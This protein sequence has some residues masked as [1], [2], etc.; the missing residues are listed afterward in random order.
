M[1]AYA[2]KGLTLAQR[3]FHPMEGECYALIWGIMHFKQYLH[4]N[5]FTLRIDHKPLEWLATV[6]DAHG[7]RGRWIDM[8]QDFS[9][10]ILHR[11]GLK[12]TNIDALSRNPVGQATN[13]DDFSEEIQD[14]ET[15]QDDSIETTGRIFSVQYGKESDWFGFRRH[16]RE[17]TEHHRCYFGINHWHWS[18]D[19]QLFMLNVVTEINQEEDTNSL[20]EDVEATDN[21]ESQN[22]GPAD[23]R[24]SLKREMTRYYDRQQQL[25]L[26][27]VAQK[28]SEFGEHELGHMES[29]EEETC[30][31]DTRSIDIWK[32]ATCLGLLKGG[33]LPNTVDPEESKR[34]RKRITNY[35]WKEERFYF[36]VYMCPNQRKE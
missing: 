26:V 9:F 1:V 2:N 4:R 33:I 35:C 7:R 36:K 27:L 21:E 24:Q 12:H 19:H 18:E 25:E 14:I 3:K 8:L 10:K 23:G 22:L 16:S 30:E 31:M 34:V 29:G 11:P 5:H 13:D 6:S 17:L 28:L 20:M 15:M 32:D